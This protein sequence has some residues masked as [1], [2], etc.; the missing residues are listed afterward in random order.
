MDT[1]LR[2]W[3]F[4][5]VESSTRDES[6]KPWPSHRGEVCYLL[7]VEHLPWLADVVEL[8]GFARV[9][10]GTDDWFMIVRRDVGGCN[11]DCLHCSSDDRDEKRAKARAE[12]EEA[13][14]L[15]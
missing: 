12:L 15:E 5:V 14:A 1:E 13:G 4:Y 9:S 7:L 11:G 10:I 6:I 2:E 8:P 3:P